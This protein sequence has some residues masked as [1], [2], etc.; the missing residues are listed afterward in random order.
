MYDSVHGLKL[1]SA[2]AKEVLRPGQIKEVQAVKMLCNLTGHRR[3]ARLA[4]FDY[5]AQH[6]KS[7]CKRCGARM[8]RS[9]DR[10]WL[11]AEPSPSPQKSTPEAP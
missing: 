6:W 5:D 1:R 4:R 9:S 3:S 2:H 11:L 10:E 7:S 8:Y